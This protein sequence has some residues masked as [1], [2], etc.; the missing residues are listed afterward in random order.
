M[1]KNKLANTL[2][3]EIREGVFYE[4]PDCEAKSQQNFF[5]HIVKLLLIFFGCAGV[6]YC[7]GDSFDLL[8]NSTHVLLALAFVSLYFLAMQSMRKKG[9]RLMMGAGVLL[10]LFL[11]YFNREALQNSLQYLYSM[12][13]ESYNSYYGF[14]LP[15]FDTGK[16]EE[17]A[18]S[19]ALFVLMLP[20]S[21]LLACS[22]AHSSRIRYSIAA[23]LPYMVLMMAS[24]HMPD[25]LPMYMV[26]GSFLGL[27]VIGNIAFCGDFFPRVHT[28]HAS[29]SGLRG[30]A[31][32]CMILFFAVSAYLGYGLFYPKVENVLGPIRY[33]VYNSSFRELYEQIRTGYSAGGINGGQINGGG[34]LKFNHTVHLI[35]EADTDVDQYTYLKGYVGEVYNGS[36]WNALPAS[37]Y[38]SETWQA[39][40]GYDEYDI[41]SM[42]YLLSESA[43]ELLPDLTEVRWFVRLPDEH[44]GD[45][46]YLCH[47][48]AGLVSDGDGTVMNT[49]WLTRAA[50]GVLENAYDAYYYPDEGGWTGAGFSALQDDIITMQNLIG[51]AITDDVSDLLNYAQL[52]RLYRAFVYEYDLEVPDRVSRLRDEYA[53]MTFKTVAEAVQFVQEEVSKDAVYTLLPERC[54]YGEDFIEYFMYEQKEGYCTYFASAAVMIFRCLGIP[55]RFAQGYIIPPV[56]AGAEVSIDDSY[57][58]AWAEIYVDGFGWMPVEVTPGFGG[59]PGAF[60]PDLNQT[61]EAPPEEPTGTEQDTAQSEEDS[62]PTLPTMNTAQTAEASSATEEGSA[63]TAQSGTEETVSGNAFIHENGGAS[64]GTGRSDENVGTVISA[65]AL[66]TVRNI[67]LLTVLLLAA[68]GFLYSHRRARV[69]ARR[70]KFNQKS[71]RNSFLAVYRALCHMSARYYI[72]VEDDSDPH[73]LSLYYPVEEELWADIQH[74]A[75]EAAFSEH[76]ITED[77]KR[78]ML[79]VY[80]KCCR[81]AAGKLS[82]MKKLAFYI[83]DGYR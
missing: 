59:L 56:H 18:G 67:A 24:G 48:Y 52:E 36:G 51:D 82:F 78:L 19:I 25:A 7:L 54:P 49:A 8:Y 77:K 5:D 76:E 74:T 53:G 72:P 13:A 71:S 40:S 6:M 2:G 32:C 45:G 17:G 55:A 65:S 70:R 63:H 34:K 57:A 47:P 14:H 73:E 42:S 31:V 20:V 38:R 26:L 30:L 79:G 23:F 12:I 29:Q 69:A 27:T 43:G 4:R 10:A 41:M 80:H 37:A 3:I 50:G 83:W 75:Q 61:Q 64:D 33:T 21:F 11:I 39:L 62:E 60:T 15:L 68:A 1:K 58:H 46:S 22:G 28:D 81:H 44:V 66:R 16:P 35:V 9:R